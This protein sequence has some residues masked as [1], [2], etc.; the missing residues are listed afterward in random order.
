M[1]ELEYTCHEQYYGSELW[2]FSGVKS[3]SSARW[4]Y[5]TGM[6]VDQ[7]SS[8]LLEFIKQLNPPA[9]YLEQK[10]KNEQGAAAAG[11]S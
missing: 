6:T 5:L 1:S 11:I 7:E 8:E 4:N 10:N 2:L 9:L 3:S